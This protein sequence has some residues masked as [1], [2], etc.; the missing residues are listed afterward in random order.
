MDKVK[1]FYG[2]KDWRDLSYTLKIARG[3]KCERCG[4]TAVEK[5]DWKKLIGHHKT[6]L[7][8]ANVSNPTISLNPDEVEIICMDCHNKE[9]RRFGYRKQVYIVWG[10]P[11]SGKS[12]LVKEIMQYGDIV[13][14]MDRLWEAVTMQPEYSKPNNV[15]F[16]IFA[17]RDNLLDQIK[18]RHGQWYDAYII[19]GYPDANERDRLAKTLGAELIYCEATE[20]ECYDRRR[21]SGKP[22]EW[23]GYIKKWWE[24]YRRGIPPGEG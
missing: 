18:T 16:N 12:T 14:D 21:E 3:G 8:E 22:I 11:L 24:D 15:R 5:E 2:R 19:G 13:L 10:S 17:L 6:E 20:Q 1:Q 4:F 9:H 7:T 23:D